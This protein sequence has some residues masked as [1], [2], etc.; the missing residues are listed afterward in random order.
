[1]QG[2]SRHLGPVVRSPPQ[3]YEDAVTEAVL[4]ATAVLEAYNVP[5]PP[6]SEDRTAFLERLRDAIAALVDRLPL[7]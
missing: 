5:V 2:A 1:M 3:S 7:E 6:E 4:T